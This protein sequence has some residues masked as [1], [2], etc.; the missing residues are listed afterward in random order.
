MFLLL[1]WG[2]F[3]PYQ[4]LAVIFSGF[5][6][7]KYPRFDTALP[8]AYSP[9]TPD[10]HIEIPKPDT[11]H[12]E[13][14]L[15]ADRLKF[16]K[17]L[18]TAVTKALN[19]IQNPS[20]F[21]ET[22]SPSLAL[23]LS[24]FQT[25]TSALAPYLPDQPPSTPLTAPPNPYKSLTKIL[26]NLQKNLQ[27]ILQNY[28]NFSQKFDKSWPKIFNLRET[29]ISKIDINFSEDESVTNRKIFRVE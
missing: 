1:T 6:A 25:L 11:N 7:D 17:L 21:Q 26:P 24:E 15:D 4:I 2:T 12:F 5:Y 16:P 19:G 20:R 18:R 27:K 29:I 9:T 8:A 3:S 14:I 23:Q 13:S 10:F 22:H 28:Q